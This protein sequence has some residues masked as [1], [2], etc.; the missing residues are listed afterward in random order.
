MQEKPLDSAEFTQFTARRVVECVD[1]VA[2]PEVLETGWWVVAGDFEGGLRGWRFA[3]VVEKGGIAAK[4][5]R[6]ERAGVVKWEGPRLEDWVSSLTANE[7]VAAVEDLQQL[8]AADTLQQGNLTRVLQAP[9]APGVVPAAGALYDLLRAEHPSP[10]GGYAQIRSGDC[11]DCGDCGDVDPATGIAPLWL[12][13]A[14]PELFLSRNGPEIRTT[15]I[16]GTA[17]CAPD[18]AAK[19][20]MESLF[21][22]GEVAAQ[23]SQ[24]CE[25]GTVEIL[26]PYIAEHPGLVQLVR[27]VRGTLSQAVLAAPG[28]GW[29][30]IFAALFPPASVDGFP[31]AAAR[32]ELARLEGRARGPYCGIFGWVDGATGRAELAVTIRSFWWQAGHLHFGTGAGITAASN[33]HAEWEET[34]LKARRLVGL[35][36]HKQEVGNE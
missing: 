20:E 31:P 35:A 11:G 33:P 12:V 36:S 3:E 18:L 24:I 9:T 10:Y 13:S 29:G 7:Y 2:R 19:D 6:D 16:K 5:G 26:P 14:S 32:A 23:F 28:G 1:L 21:V 34:E 4:T 22:S 8:M 30:Q 17:A 25:A 27:E 15:P